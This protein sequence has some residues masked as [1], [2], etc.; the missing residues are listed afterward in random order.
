M[1]CIVFQVWN[2]IQSTGLPRMATQNPFHAEPCT[3]EKPMLE[4]CLTRVAGTGRMK[5]TATTRAE[6]YLF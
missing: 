6:K 5:A 1:P 2:G 4:E 3:I